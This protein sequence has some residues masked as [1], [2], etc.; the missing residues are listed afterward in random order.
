MPQIVI[1]LVYSYLVLALLFLV[2][3]VALFLIGKHT[4][5]EQLLMSLW[6]TPIGPLS[7]IFFLQDYW[8]PLSVAS[9]SIGFVPILLEDVIFAFATAGTASVV[10]KIVFRRSVEVSAA[11]VHLTRVFAVLI[12]PAAIAISLWFFV[13]MN[14]IFTTAVSAIIAAALMISLRKDLVVSAV[15]SAVLFT[16][17]VAITYLFYSYILHAANYDELMRSWWMLIDTPLDIRILRIPL[18]ELIWAFTSGLAAG[19]FYAFATGRRI[20]KV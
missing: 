6:F 13:E 17:A 16:G 20:V 18:T 11:R 9:F 14:S 10:Y 1:P 4:R 3:W 19:P 8:Q 7:E 15:A 2:V 12:V 5:K